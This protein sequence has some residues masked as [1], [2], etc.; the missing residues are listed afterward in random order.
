VVSAIET[1]LVEVQDGDGWLLS[2]FEATTSRLIT[3]SYSNL[4]VGAKEKCLD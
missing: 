4:F 1:I 2:W 3:E